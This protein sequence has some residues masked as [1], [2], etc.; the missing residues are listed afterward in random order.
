MRRNLTLPPQVLL[1]SPV[2]ETG[3]F[4]VKP[5]VSLAD[6]FDQR[7]AAAAQGTALTTPLVLDLSGSANGKS[8]MYPWDKNNFQPRIAIAWSPAFESRPLHM[9][10]G[11]EGKSSI[12]SGFAMT[13]DYFGQALAVLFDLN[14]TLGF[15]SNTTISANTYNVTNKPAPL[16]TGFN[17]QVRPLPGI[18]VPA[19]VSFPRNQPSDFRRRIESSLDSGLWPH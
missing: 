3:G 12:R 14:N 19:N 4:E 17:Q 15:S 11:S 7:V 10:F 18:A 5:T 2:H 6:Y 8:P 9:L 1:G 16:F 13:N